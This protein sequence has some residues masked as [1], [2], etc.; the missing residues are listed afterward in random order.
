MVTNPWL[1]TIF[2]FYYSITVKELFA[3]A[4]PESEHRECAI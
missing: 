4:G 3:R 1:D 2:F